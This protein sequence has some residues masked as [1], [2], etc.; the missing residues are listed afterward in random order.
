M[1]LL[2]DK[3]PALRGCRH[4]V[5]EKTGLVQVNLRGIRGVESYDN[6]NWVFGFL[7][8]AAGGI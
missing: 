7:P 3:P 8:G 2:S 4:W 6:F 1:P 5:L